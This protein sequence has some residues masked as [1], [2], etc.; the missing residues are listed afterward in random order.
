MFFLFQI[1][2]AKIKENFN[3]DFS[4]VKGKAF[5]NGK[6]V[7]NKK[8]FFHF[9]N[10]SLH[11]SG[12]VFEGIRVYNHK[13]LFLIDHIDR[14]KTSC[15][16]MLLKDS[17]S[18]SKLV[19]V[20]EELVNIN[21]I[22]DGYIRPIVFRSSD[23]MSPAINNC[24]SNLAIACWKWANLFGKK[25]IKIETA[26]LKKVDDNFFPVAAKSS[27]SYQSA[28]LA[29]E[30]SRKKGFDDVLFLDLQNNVSETSACN[31]F[32]I[33]NKKVF[34]PSSKNILNGITRQAVI[35]ICKK[36]LNIEV[37]KGNFNIKEIYKA[38]SFFITGTA[39][40]IKNVSKLNKVKFSQNNKIFD[41]IK[42]IYD[43]KKILGIKSVEDI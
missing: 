32:W 11:F 26:S 38:Q 41:E 19:K 6:F 28:I 25:K 16:L 29:K 34:T 39:T 17:F 5:L 7:D 1:I 13:P 9:L 27:A 10:H 23:S 2:K 20:C 4:K 30:I 33:N 37:I 21:N 8:A 36:Y 18:N 15:N 12:S 31:I 22:K 3:L 43:E 42:K 35:K 24:K 40:E 14:L